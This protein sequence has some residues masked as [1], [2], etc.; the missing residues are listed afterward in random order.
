MHA[1]P[2]SI[3]HSPSEMSTYIL[4]QKSETLITAPDGAVHHHTKRQDVEDQITLGLL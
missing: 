2:K 1:S 4:L 3:V